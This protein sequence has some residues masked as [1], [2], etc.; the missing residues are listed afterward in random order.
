[1]T[2]TAGWSNI[3]NVVEEHRVA[4][5]VSSRIAAWADVRSRGLQPADDLHF[6][7]LGFNRTERERIETG[8]KLTTNRVSSGNGGRGQS[9]TAGNSGRPTPLGTHLPG[10]P[11]STPA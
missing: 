1:L 4:T 3:Q 10:S 5:L 7:K 8:S 2:Q 6:E 9:W 11:R